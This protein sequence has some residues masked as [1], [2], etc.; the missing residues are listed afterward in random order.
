MVWFCV[1]LTTGSRIPAK[2]GA[3][4]R[5]EDT[6]IKE[7]F[8]TKSYVCKALFWGALGVVFLTIFVGLPITHWML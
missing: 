5:Y 3:V 8:C 7:A 4:M 2:R 1:E 6:E